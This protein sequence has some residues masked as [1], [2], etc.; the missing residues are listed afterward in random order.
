MRAVPK[1]VRSRSAYAASKASSCQSKPPQRSAVQVSIGRRIERKSASSP[2]SPMPGVRAREDRGGRLALQI[3]DRVARVGQPAQRRRLLLD[4]PAHERAVLVERRALARR[5]L[6][7]REG[8][9]RA[10]LGRRTPRGRNRA[11][12]RRDEAH[13]ARASD[14]AAAADRLLPGS[15]GT[16]T[17]CGCRRPA[18]TSGS[19]VRQRGHGRP[20]RR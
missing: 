13:E 14:Y 15:S 17:P 2:V 18:P 3:V 1:S 20:T 10:A 6:L 5:V 8:D 19:R 4:E 16:S 9:L 12:T 7:E 11:W